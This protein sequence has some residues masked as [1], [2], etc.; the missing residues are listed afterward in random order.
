[1]QYLIN[2]RVTVDTLLEVNAS[3]IDEAIAKARKLKVTDFV[4][5]KGEYNDGRYVFKGILLADECDGEVIE[6]GCIIE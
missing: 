6:K 5:I 4:K 2:A 1:M 3:G